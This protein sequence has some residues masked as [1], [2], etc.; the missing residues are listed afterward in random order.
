LSVLI[1]EIKDSGKAMS[2]SHYNGNLPTV[3]VFGPSLSAVSGVSTHLQQL[4]NSELSSEFR[5]F[6]FQVGREGRKESILARLWRFVISPIYLALKIPTVKPAIIHLNTSMDPKAF[7]R[8]TVYLLVARLL[9]IRTVYQIHGGELPQKFFKGKKILDSILRR[10]LQIPDAVVVLSRIENSAYQK[11]VRPRRLAIIPNAVNLR[12]YR[13]S[14]G[15]DFNTD[16]LKLAYMGRLASVKG[17]LNVIEA[18][19]I[20]KNQWGHKNIRFDIAGSGPDEEHLKKKVVELGL[21]KEVRFLGPLFG[22]RKKTFW[23]NA[24]IFVFPTYHDEGL[25]YAVLESLA[26]G[27][28][29]ITTHV[30][31]ISDAVKNMVHGLFVEPHNSTSIAKAIL[32]MYE[33]KRQLKKMSLNCIEKANKNYSIE[34][35]AHQFKRLYSQVIEKDKKS[36]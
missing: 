6:H 8:D 14:E 29:L 33:D 9:G 32:Q 28:P 22:G 25:P 34:R 24:Q 7:W 10:V 30:G 27:T 5:L 4:F 31:G 2:N 23:Q 3:L 35:L 26:S 12:D 18:M 21:H 17:I 11:F 16:I 36:Y 19:D 1:T 13:Q 15:K 20:L